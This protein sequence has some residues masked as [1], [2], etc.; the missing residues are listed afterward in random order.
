ME[1]P[2]PDLSEIAK[3]YLPCEKVVINNTWIVNF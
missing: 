3:A 2:I 1:K